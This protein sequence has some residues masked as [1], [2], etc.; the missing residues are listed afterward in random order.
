[1]K[2][3]KKTHAELMN[4]RAVQSKR[5]IQQL[6]KFDELQYNNLVFDHAYLYMEHIGWNDDPIRS[7]LLESADFWI[8][9]ANQYAIVDEIFLA[10]M[11]DNPE[12]FSISKNLLLSDYNF[13]HIQ[14]KFRPSSDLVR[15]ILKGRETKQH[16]VLTSH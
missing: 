11:R 1:M 5:S 14:G 15:R 9:W 7:I 16:Q 10:N 3:K 4:L 12:Q 13:A 8:W 2:S 6:F